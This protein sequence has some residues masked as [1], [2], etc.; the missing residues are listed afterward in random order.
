ML[1]NGKGRLTAPMCLYDITT[2]NQYPYFLAF[3]GMFWNATLNPLL[4]GHYYNSVG[5]RVTF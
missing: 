4:R 1:N 2:F 3:T 5:T